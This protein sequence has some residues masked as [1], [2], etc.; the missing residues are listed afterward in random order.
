MER[1]RERK[2]SVAAAA[3]TLEST[4]VHSTH[5]VYGVDCLLMCCW[6]K[7]FWCA[8]TFEFLCAR[9]STIRRSNKYMTANRYLPVWCVR[10]IVCMSM[11]VSVC[12]SKYECRGKKHRQII[13][14]QQTIH[15][16]KNNWTVVVRRFF[17][18]LLFYF[19]FFSSFVCCFV[20]FK[21]SNI[22]F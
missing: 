11:C 15:K 10:A 8:N 6:E 18:F 2:S 20:F 22:Y 13:Y 5:T 1:G 21:C 12:A 17:S 7:T 14:T 19:I 3:T 4:N 16:K 9:F